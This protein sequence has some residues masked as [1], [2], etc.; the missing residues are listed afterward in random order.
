MWRIVRDIVGMGLPTSAYRPKT[1]AESVLY[2][3]VR[4]HFETF[5][6]EAA[7]V[8][9][10]GCLPR[11][12]EEEFRGFLRCGLLAGGFARFHCGSCGLDRL[13][14]FSC[15]G[16]AVCPSFGGR[17]MAKHAAPLV[18]H[19]FPEV[20]V[21]QWVLSLPHRLRYHELCRAVSSVFVR[22]VRGAGAGGSRGC[23]GSGHEPPV[24]CAL[25]PPVAQDRLHLISD[26]QVE[27]EL[28]H[29]LDD[30]TAHLIFDQ[31]ELLERRPR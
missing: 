2:Q 22:A 23:G 19:V 28:R 9:E 5:R 31:L 25:R 21:R 24:V 7:P 27:L 17:R 18:D 1:P 14:P 30:D 12:I 13:V 6:A 29:P 16:R 11:F 3:V 15:K 4:D 8:H 10:P 26:G 20:P